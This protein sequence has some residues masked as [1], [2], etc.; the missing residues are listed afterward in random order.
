MLSSQ[1]KKLLSR[2]LGLILLGS[3]CFWFAPSQFGGETTYVVTHGTSMAPRFHTGDLAL[4]RPKSSYK[5]GEIVAYDSK[6]LHTVV[7]HRIIARDGARYVFKGDNNN[8]IDPEHPKA[9]QLVGA[10][11]LHIPGAGATLLS[12]RS[13]LLVAALI[14]VGLLILTGSVYARRRRLR[15]RERRGGGGAHLPAPHLPRPSGTPAAGIVAVGLL[16]LLPFLILALVA[17]T[18]APTARSSYAIPYRQSGALAYTAEAPPG[19]AYPEGRVTTGEPI[20]AHI[21]KAIDFSFAYRL[22]ATGRQRLGGTIALDAEVA[23]TVGWKTTI[24]LAPPTPFRGGRGEVSGTLDLTSLF[25]LLRSV[26][27]ATALSAGYTLT[28]VPKV[29]AAGTVDALPIHTK[30][31][32]KAAFTLT[33]AEIQSS[34]SSSS[35]A[36]SAAPSTEEKP[37]A[38]PLASTESGT[39]T[40]ARTAPATLTLGV[41]TLSVDT[42]RNVALIAIAL[43][44]AA[45]LLLLLFLT[46]LQALLAPSNPREEA[47]TIRA[48]FGRFIVPVERVWQLPG[49]PVIDV[50]DIA[51]LA[52]IAEHYDRSIL[53]ERSEE[54]ISFWVTDE[55]GQF[56]YA[57]GAHAKAATPETLETLIGAPT[58]A[59]ARNGFPE[60][61]FAADRSPEESPPGEALPEKTF[62]APVYAEEP[63]LDGPIKA[64]P[65]PRAHPRADPP[66]DTWTAPAADDPEAVVQGEWTPRR[67][68]K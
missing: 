54:G 34:T 42:A 55:S 30:F 56:R 61:G 5:V 66:T 3:L 26:E 14:A 39:A 13:P 52:Q 16:G 36:S 2:A 35:G 45:V 68:V 15:R 11:W 64:F 25:A 28:I 51:A 43:I 44:V 57:L 20:F 12:I 33:P 62:T 46:P 1:T 32:P 21:V 24:Q 17:F 29:T 31:S 4:V 23:S 65:D 53:E 6:M 22:H 38:N 60:G 19:P 59:A 41:T 47:E 10:L 37:A 18:K 50:A 7:L 48:K 49:V 58:T 40:G 9:S 63:D 67:P 8:F 27:K